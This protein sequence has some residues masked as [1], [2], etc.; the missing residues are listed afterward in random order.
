[1]ALTPAQ[2]QTLKTDIAANVNP[3][4]QPGS[5]Y[6]ATAVNAVPN[7][8]DGNDAIAFWYNQP[9]SPA[10]I[11]YRNNIPVQTVGKSMLSADVANVTAANQSRLQ[12]LEQYSG[13]LFT[14]SADTE[15]G[16]ADVFSAAGASGTRA[17]LHAVW[18]RTALRIEAVFATGTGTDVAPATLVAEGQ[19]SASEVQSARLLP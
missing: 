18:R 11:V 3:T 15:A 6:A 19:T 14:G 17:L 1:M 8:S 10:K 7:N 16:F 5:I 9:T 12:T 4:G 2:L 13:G